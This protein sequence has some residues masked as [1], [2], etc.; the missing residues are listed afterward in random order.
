VLK[1]LLTVAIAGAVAKVVLDKLTANSTRE[2][3]LWAEATDDVESA[4]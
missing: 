3:D 4:R 1:K 2:A